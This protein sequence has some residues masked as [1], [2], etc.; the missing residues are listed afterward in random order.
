[1]V[2]VVDGETG[3]NYKTRNSIKIIL[4]TH[5]SFFDAIFFQNSLKMY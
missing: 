3:T 5:N 4:I 1:V 2:R